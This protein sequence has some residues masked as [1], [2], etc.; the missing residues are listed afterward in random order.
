MNKKLYCM[1]FIGIGKFFD[2]SCGETITPPT[3]LVKSP[4][5]EQDQKIAYA[6]PLD[7]LV[8]LGDHGIWNQQLTNSNFASCI[9]I[10]SFNKQ[11]RAHALRVYHEGDYKTLT[12]AHEQLIKPLNLWRAQNS[13]MLIKQK[14][15]VYINKLIPPD[16][17]N[18]RIFESA[19][20]LLAA[21]NYPESTQSCIQ[22]LCPPGTKLS[23]III[24]QLT[25]EN[26]FYQPEQKTAAHEWEMLRSLHQPHESAHE[27]FWDG[28]GLLGQLAQHLSEC[29]AVSIRPEKAMI[30]SAPPSKIILN[31][32]TPFALYQSFAKWYLHL[33]QKFDF[34]KTKDL[35]AK[36][37]NYA[38]QWSNICNIITAK[39]TYMI[40]FRERLIKKGLPHGLTPLSTISHDTSSS[41]PLIILS[42]PSG[43][44]SV[45]SPSTQSSST[46]DSQQTTQTS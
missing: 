12:Q 19:P 6:S 3:K 5:F 25:L 33:A 18:L 13:L 30:T 8:L 20:C 46:Q 1:F 21:T 16:I 9:I 27:Y 11:P 35:A 37:C 36:Y 32:I 2:L 10:G 24:Q 34:P 26:G 28:A 29:Q 42:P 39:P 40:A 23:S 44:E 15:S 4:S 22:A 45:Q 41:A 17:Q 31:N 7:T 14:E 38:A 43:K